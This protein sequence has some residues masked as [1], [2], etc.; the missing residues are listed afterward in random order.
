MSL[1]EAKPVPGLSVPDRKVRARSTFDI[2]VD[3]EVP[4]F[5]ERTQFVPD[6][7]EAYVFDRITTIAILAGFKHNRSVMI[8]GYHGTGK[9][10]HI[11]RVAARCARRWKCRSEP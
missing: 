7:D 5:T 4:A 8:Q 1:V 11:E 3:M 2:D 9:S 6:I 10:T